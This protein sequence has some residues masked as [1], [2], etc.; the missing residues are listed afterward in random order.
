M[1]ADPQD[2]P[3]Q[4]SIASDVPLRCDGP[5][6]PRELEDILQQE[7]SSIATASPETQSDSSYEERKQ[8]D[9]QFQ[10]DAPISLSEIQFLGQEVDANETETP[11][12]S[13]VDQ[14]DRSPTE[15]SDVRLEVDQPNQQL[16]LETDSITSS[17]TD[18]WQLPAFPL[19]EIGALRGLHITSPLR[20]EQ[21]DT[22][23]ESVSGLVVLGEYRGDQQH[24]EL[25]QLGQESN[26]D[27]T[28]IMSNT[29]SEFSQDSIAEATNLHR[30]IQ[31]AI[32]WLLQHNTRTYH[33]A[34]IT[35]SIYW[36]IRSLPSF[37]QTQIALAQR[38]GPFRLQEPD[39]EEWPDE[40]TGD[41][42]GDITN[43]PGWLG[44]LLVL[45]DLFDHGL[46]DI[47][48]R[49][50]QRGRP[51]RSRWFPTARQYVETIP[52]RELDDPPDS[53]SESDGDD[54][55]VEMSVPE[56]VNTE[57]EDYLSS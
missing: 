18:I 19:R 16:F 37:Y 15:D 45:D 41:D 14:L 7:Q 51:R 34:G 47:S 12:I 30:L 8:Q 57:K 42:I 50:I 20:V 5:I 1:F 4:W 38:H 32:Y 52:E 11:G 24:E 39:D 23:P 21:P 43:L 13:G 29:T 22:D 10:G 9:V 44:Y 17:I 55:I 25:I 28:S 49:R 26:S 48:G 56:N 27:T 6:S 54:L 35:R 46:L 36:A 53:G 2:S 40:P 33:N 3:Y 31:R